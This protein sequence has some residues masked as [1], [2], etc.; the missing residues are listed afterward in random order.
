VPWPTYVLTKTVTGTYNNSSGTPAKGRVTFTPTSRILIDNELVLSTDTLT[1]SLNTS[2]SFSIEL[3]T[4]D[5]PRLTPTDFAYQ[6]NVRLYGVKP[7]KYYIK[8]PYGDGTDVDISSS[9]ISASP[10]EDATTQNAFLRGTAG[11]AGSGIL[12]GSGAPPNTLGRDGDIYVNTDNGSY[13]GPK[14]SG[15]W[16]SAPFYTPGLTLREIH[17]Q[18][19]ASSTWSITHSLGGRP[20]VTVVDSSGTVV[21]GEVVYNSDTSVTV[22]FSAPFS[23]FAYLT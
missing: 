5:N 7:A 1:A 23:G 16:P 22:L 18:G 11:P 9:L 6:V 8:V 2:G 3:P 17:T 14:A 20:S 10:L 19:S 15:S 21:I 13:Y 4:T 12:T